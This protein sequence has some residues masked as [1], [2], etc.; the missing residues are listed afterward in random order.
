[1]KEWHIQGTCTGL[2]EKG[3]AREEATHLTVIEAAAVQA[4]KRKMCCPVVSTQAFLNISSCHNTHAFVTKVMD[5]RQNMHNGRQKERAGFAESNFFIH[6]LLATISWKCL[7]VRIQSQLKADYTH[8][9]IYI[10]MCVCGERLKSINYG[11]TIQAVIRLATPIRKM[12]CSASNGFPRHPTC[13][14]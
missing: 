12:I 1:M 6:L 7:V 8:T 14:Q 5:L 2:P 11:W 9:Y 10:Y 4:G 3:A 13:S